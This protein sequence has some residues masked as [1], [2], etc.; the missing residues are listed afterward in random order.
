MRK[1]A[2]PEVL[3]QDI[4][5]NM[6]LGPSSHFSGACLWNYSA[7]H[8]ATSD[9]RKRDCDCQA[10]VATSNNGSIPKHIFHKKEK[11]KYKIH[12]LEPAALP[13]YKYNPTP[14]TLLNRP[15]F[16]LPLFLP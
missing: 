4:P 16:R 2:S 12:L 15:Y 7:L 5:V 6:S 3:K 10:S 14:A 9:R 1:T 8:C 13:M 11:H